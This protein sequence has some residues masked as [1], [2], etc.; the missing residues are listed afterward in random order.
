[1]FPRK[2]AREDAGGEIV[3][4]TKLAEQASRGAT[5]E[6]GCQPH[7]PCCRAETNMAN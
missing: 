6:A 2:G 1:M 5:G 4:F 7:E 3:P